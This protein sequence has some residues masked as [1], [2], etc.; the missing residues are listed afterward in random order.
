ML[1]SQYSNVR[2]A[3]RH[4]RADHDFDILI[5]GCQELHQLFGWELIQAI[6]LQRGYLR[7]RDAQH[8][9]RFTLLEFACLGHANEMHRIDSAECAAKSSTTSRTP[10]PSPFRGW[11]KFAALVTVPGKMW[12]CIIKD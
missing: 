9:S 6:V 3:C 10:D 8:F 5:Q 2:N 4:A 12:P 11:N 1:N 7:L